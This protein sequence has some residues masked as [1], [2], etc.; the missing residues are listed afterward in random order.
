MSIES[1]AAD[2]HLNLVERILHDIVGIKLVH[3]A[4][5]NIDIWLMWFRKHEEFRA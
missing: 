4:T 2:R 1:F 3:T 5:Y